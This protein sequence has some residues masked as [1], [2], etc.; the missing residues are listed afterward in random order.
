MA[1]KKRDIPAAYTAYVLE[2]G[3]RP[4]SVKVFADE[5]GLEEAAFYREYSG[6]EA[7]EQTLF[8][9]YFQETLEVLE[10][11]E[12]YQTYNSREK[13]LALFFTWLETLKG[14]R[15]LVVFMDRQKLTPFGVGYVAPTQSLFVDTARQ[16]IT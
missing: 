14:Q 3:Q 12:T 4:P 7:I 8:L 15:S 9:G 10:K 2:K 16:L 5:L 11:D 1:K 6:F 13:V